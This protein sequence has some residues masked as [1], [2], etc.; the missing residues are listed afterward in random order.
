MNKYVNKQVSKLKVTEIFLLIKRQHSFRILMR[1]PIIN[2]LLFLFQIFK[3]VFGNLTP[4]GQ[5]VVQNR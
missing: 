5:E 1:R 2:I 4:G 3:N